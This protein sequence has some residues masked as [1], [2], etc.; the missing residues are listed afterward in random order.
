MERLF[1]TFVIGNKE[2]KNRVVCPPMV[3]SIYREDGYVSAENIE[4]Y[5]KIAKGGTGLIIQEA[6]CVS[7]TGRLSKA[8]L[9]IWEDGQISGLRQITDAVHDEGGTIVLQL[10]H[11]GLM[12]VDGVRDCPSNFSFSNPYNG[13]AIEGRE[14]TS[15]HIK[16]IIGQFINAGRRAYEAGYDG[17]ELHGAHAYLISQFLNTN[18][19]KRT[20]LYGEQPELFV[21]EILDGIRKAVGN[22]FI[23]GM[24]MGAF[25]PTL[26]SSLAYAKTLESHLDYLNISFGFLSLCQ[27][28]KPD[29]YPFE[30]HIYATEEIKAAVNIPVFAANNITSP[31]MADDILVK[32]NADMVNI[33]RGILINPNWTNDAI[34]GQDTGHCLHCKSCAFPRE[35]SKCP[36]RQKYLK[37]AK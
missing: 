17:I 29:D 14:M 8:Q 1:Q 13:T 26:E 34:A 10:H 27:L 23:L 28:K 16:E 32:T 19:N 35:S 36:G 21:I 31:Q 5:R 18:V 24:R 2:L 30:A 11:A 7:D 4:H 6:A 22:A 20:D 12:S 33:G 9:G 15:E 25:E 37:T 3:C